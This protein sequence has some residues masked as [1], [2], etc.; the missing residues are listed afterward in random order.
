MAEDS[1]ETHDEEAAAEAKERASRR[2]ALS[3]NLPSMRTGSKSKGSL[4]DQINRA[5][6]GKSGYN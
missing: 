5:K 3:D 6:S 4:K 1:K 2:K